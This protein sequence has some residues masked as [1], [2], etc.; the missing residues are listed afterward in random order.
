MPCDNKN[1]FLFWKWNTCLLFHS[2]PAIRLRFL[3]AI[4]KNEK[5]LSGKCQGTNLE[6][7]ES[8]NN[9]YP[10]S[11]HTVIWKERKIN[12]QE[13]STVKIGSLFI[14]VNSIGF[15]KKLAQ[16]QRGRGWY[17]KFYT[18]RLP[19]RALT[20]YPFIKHFSR[21]RFPFHM[22][23]IDKCYP[24]LLPSLLELFIPLIKLLWMQCLL[25]WFRTF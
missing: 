9:V 19:P 13:Y 24:F 12:S 6:S 7:L 22:P 4:L 1:T 16:S 21:K 2:S 5:N 8:L 10:M 17:N 25:K 20:P 14:I 23:C 18:G 15:P 3:V 11:F